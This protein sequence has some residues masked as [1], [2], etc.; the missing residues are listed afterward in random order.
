VSQY[1]SVHQTH[2]QRACSR[3]PPTSSAV[4]ACDRS[5]NG[6]TPRSVPVIGDK[7]ALDRIRAIR[8]E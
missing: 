8:L 7:T 6:L 3:R 2:P 4:A 5:S 1:F